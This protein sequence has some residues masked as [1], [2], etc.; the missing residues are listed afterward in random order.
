M[1]HSYLADTQALIKFLEGK[2][3]I[4]KEIDDIFTKFDNNEILIFLSAITLVEILYL[5]ERNRININI[6]D[7]ESLQKL[8]PNLIFIELNV[9]II[10][11]AKNITDIN[12]LHDRLIAATARYLKIP[13]LTND[14]IIRKSKFVKSV[15]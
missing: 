11:T 7:I 6:E 9:E 4:N 12:E 3:V 14:P 8:N 13:I 10:K 1:K 15:K 5:E 2:K